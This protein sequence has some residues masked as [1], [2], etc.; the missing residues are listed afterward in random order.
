MSVFL[1]VLGVLTTAAGLALV[2]A[3]LTIYDG[4]F[5]TDVIT[6]GTIAAVGGLILVGIGLAVH[7]LRRIERALAARPMSRPARPGEAPG[8]PV[9]GVAE[10][11]E[12]AVRIPIPPAPQTAPGPPPLPGARVRPVLAEDAAIERLRSKFPTLARLDSAP[13]L[14]GADVSLTPRAP[15]HAEDAGE[16]KDAATAGP[17]ANAVASAR[18]P[19]GPDAKARLA[20]SPENAKRSAFSAVWSGSRGLSAG[21][22]PSCH[23]AAGSDGAGTCRRSANGRRRRSPGACGSSR[24]DPQIRR[25]RRDGVYPLLGW[26]DR[27]RASA[28]HLAVWL[29]RGIAQSHRGKSLAFSYFWNAAATRAALPARVE[30]AIF[31]RRFLG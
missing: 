12:P 13:V 15:A 25:D 19:P 2:G 24:V 1:L 14:D 5:D 22:R 29:D 21:L 27:G 31:Q 6:P 3:G 8:M 4:A 28:R 23:P 26:I 10:P 9:A 17:A 16:A 18:L 30:L 20:T 11:P 7:E